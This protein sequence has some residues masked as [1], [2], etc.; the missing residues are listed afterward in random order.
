MR[1]SFAAPLALSLV[2]SGCARNA[3]F[4][5]ELTVPARPATGPDL[6][7]VAVFMTGDF[8]FE[9]V[10]IDP[11]HSGTALDAAPQQLRYS[12]LT[13]RPDGRVRMVVFFCESTTCRGEDP[14]AIPQ[15]WFEF[16]RAAYV[17]E[18]TRWTGTITSLPTGR[19]TAA[20]CIDR[21]EIEGC[22]GGDG[23]FCRIDG[24]HYCQA[25]GEDPGEEICLP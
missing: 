3:A 21:C 25:P 8:D 9:S 24:T 22:I 17:G 13:E 15:S 6:Y 5:I 14:S 18:R 1:C 10:A 4:E 11:V 7:A 19:P 2:I 23:S 20:D 16:E 12:V